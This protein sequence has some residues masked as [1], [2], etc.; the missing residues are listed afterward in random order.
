MKIW[1]CNFFKTSEWLT[2]LGYFPLPPSDILMQIF[3]LCR[4]LLEFWLVLYFMC[5]MT[6]HISSLKM[7]NVVTLLLVAHFLSSKFCFLLCL[8]KTFL[9]HI[10]AVI[11]NTCQ[12]NVSVF[13]LDSSMLKSHQVLQVRVWNPFLL[14]Q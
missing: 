2:L 14:V 12:I 1:K 11:H 7:M 9:N 5:S 8:Y 4:V 10:Q 6:G 3:S 13:F